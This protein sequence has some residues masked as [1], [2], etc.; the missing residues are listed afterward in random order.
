[1]EKDKM[2]YSFCGSPEY[3]SPEMLKKEGHSNSVDIY[4][5]GLIL[6]EMLFGLPPFYNPD[7]RKIFHVKQIKN[8]KFYNFFLLKDVLNTEI[9][10]PENIEVSNEV[11]DLIKN[12]L[13]KNVYDRLGCDLGISEIIHHPWIKRQEFEKIKGRELSPPFPPSLKT[14]DFEQ[15]KENEK[16]MQEIKNE[17]DQR[18]VESDG[19]SSDSSDDNLSKITS[20][21]KE[22]RKN[23]FVIK[24]N[25]WHIMDSKIVSSI[26][27]TNPTPKASNLARRT[28]NQL[29]LNTQ[30]ETTNNLKN[31]VSPK[32]KTKFLKYSIQNKKD[33]G[34][35]KLRK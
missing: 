35:I 27:L 20:P 9:S 14:F 22:L 8:K 11:K 26:Q 3:M 7:F 32:T 34:A 17:K 2:A 30:V 28:N 19:V 15:S 10:F 1:M 33:G 23:K 31:I 25:N 12:L 24:S 4:G 6:Y 21:L 16:F 5:L 13:E 29:I 18:F